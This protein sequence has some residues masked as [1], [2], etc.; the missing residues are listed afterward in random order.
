MN[1]IAF[2]EK[3]GA[4]REELDQIDFTII[5]A[6]SDRV[7]IIKRVGHLKKAHHEPM[8]QPA[9]VDQ[10]RK[11]RSE[12]ALRLDVDEKLIERLFDLLLSHSFEIENKIIDGSE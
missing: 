7:K 2:E 9:R 3:L 12:I 8:M 5:K 10:I 4:F 6:L 11:T 1:E